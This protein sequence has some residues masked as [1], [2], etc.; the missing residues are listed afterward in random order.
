[1]ERTVRKSGVTRYETFRIAA[2][3]AAREDSGMQPLLTTVTLTKAQRTE[4]TVLRVI[5][6]GIIKPHERTELREVLSDLR[7]TNDVVYLDTLAAKAG[8]ANFDD[9]A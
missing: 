9:A 6:D 4:Q 2:E 5:A 3:H 8:Y 7:D 1:M